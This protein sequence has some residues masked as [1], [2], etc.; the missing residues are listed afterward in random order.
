MVSREHRDG[1]AGAL[2]HCTFPC[3]PP[4]YAPYGAQG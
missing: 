4:G 3:I 1:P 2:A